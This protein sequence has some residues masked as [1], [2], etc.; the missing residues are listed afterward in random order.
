MAHPNTLSPHQYDD[1]TSLTG[2]LGD[3]S[4]SDK[5][6]SPMFGLPSQHSGFRS[7]LSE[8]EHEEDAGD[9]EIMSDES[10]WS[11]PGY[12][13][14]TSA[15]A[16]YRHQP[17]AQ[18]VERLKAGSASRSGGTSAGIGNV[19][20][21][22]DATLAARIP[23]PRGSTSPLRDSPERG[24]TSGKGTCSPI[25]ASPTRDGAPP[26]KGGSLARDSAAM[27]DPVKAEG[28]P[29]PKLEEEETE[30]VTEPNNC[31]YNN[32]C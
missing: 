32:C 8:S 14:P 1:T 2:S 27:G 11:P 19:D 28:S 21:D 23:L 6:Q 9:E 12:R 31:S 18:N 20:D 10:P 26:Q 17:Y 4:D 30:P 16:W 22:E 13:Q 15:G 25:S 3:F 24:E 29:S 7:E 5:Q